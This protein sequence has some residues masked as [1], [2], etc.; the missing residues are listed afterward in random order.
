MPLQP[1]ISNNHEVF[2]PMNEGRT[3][4]LSFPVSSV[5]IISG[6]IH[7]RGLGYHA[8]IEIDGIRYKVIGRSC[9]MQRCACDAELIEIK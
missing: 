1:S 3:K 9:S 8:T 6:D 4:R 5:K 7:A 2:T